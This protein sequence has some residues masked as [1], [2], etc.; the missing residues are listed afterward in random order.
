M[1]RSERR[2]RIRAEASE[3]LPT[4]GIR[5]TTSRPNV[6]L[7]PVIVTLWLST[8]IIIKLDKTQ[9]IDRI[10]SNGLQS[11]NY[12]QPPLLARHHVR[13]C[14]DHVATT[15]ASA[16]HVLFVQ[17]INALFFRV[18]R[19]HIIL[20]LLGFWISPWR[21]SFQFVGNKTWSLR[22]AYRTSWKKMLKN[23]SMRI[24]DSK[25]DEETRE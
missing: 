4:P 21:S 24:N 8:L 23:A 22:I 6:V 9:K 12:S 1:V 15:R 16:F 17:V 19:N 11:Y 13:R 20:L 7:T 25:K 5:I 3:I 14:W 18:R 2:S 10:L